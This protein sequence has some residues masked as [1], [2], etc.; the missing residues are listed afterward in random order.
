ME[1]IRV[2]QTGGPDVLEL[3]D[4]DDPTP[5]DGQ[6]LIRVAA[7]GLNFIDVYHRS[8]RYPLELPTGIGLEGAGVVVDV[9]PG[10]DGVEAGDRVAWS[11]TMGSYAQ[12]VAAPVDRVVAVP[13]G[14]E[15]RVAAAVMLQGMTAHYLAR[16][17]FPLADGHTA[18][19]HAGAGGVGQLLIQLAKLAG[20]R[21]ITTV[22]TEEKAELARDAGADEVIRY[23]EVDFADETMR[24][25]PDGVDVVY[26]SVGKDTFDRSL[27]C[28]ATRGHLVL[29]GQSSGAVDPLDPQRLAAGGSL[30]LTRPTL[31]DYVATVDE[32]RARATELFELIA[33]DRLAVRIDRELPLADAADAHRY[34]EGRGTRGKVLLLP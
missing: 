8:G 32:L 7:A 19:V 30:Y 22:S 1:A 17:T 5:G 14:V 31:F 15:L 13:D 9:G 33:D 20:A 29:Y 26:E 18:L 4:V 25:A 12:L 21:V 10:V 28:L 23:T 27:S 34:I 24:L 3:A 6:V 11:G 2:E 16:S